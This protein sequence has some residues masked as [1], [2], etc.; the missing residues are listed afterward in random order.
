MYPS[1]RRFE[2]FTIQFATT[3]AERRSACH[4]RYEIFTREMGLVQFADHV[5]QSYSDQLDAALAHVILARTSDRLVG[6]LRFTLRRETRFLDEDEPLFENFIAQ[7]GES[8]VALADRG[9]ILSAFRGLHLYPQMWEHGFEFLRGCGVSF[10]VGV[11]DAEDN[12]LV[13]FH[14]MQGWGTLAHKIPQGQKAWN[15]IVRNL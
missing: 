12:A 1:A 9:V 7:H 8:A 14:E 13:R 4:L 10:V 2:G 11:I 15:V 6:T 5:S 3:E